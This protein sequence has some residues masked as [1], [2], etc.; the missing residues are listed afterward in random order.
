MPR[1][2]RLGLAVVLITALSVAP[3]VGREIQ[4]VGGGFVAGPIVNPADAG[5][6]SG[7]DVAAGVTELGDTQAP[8]V[9]EAVEAGDWQTVIRLLETLGEGEQAVLIRDSSGMLRPLSTLKAQVLAD[10]PAEGRRTFR[11]MYRPVA[12]KLL[13]D[14]QIIADPGEQTLALA[15]VVERY[16]LCA[17]AADAAQ[18]LGDLHFEGGRF[19]ESVRYYTFASSHAD[20]DPDDPQLIA[21]RLHALARAG[22]WAGFDTLADYARFRRGGAS[23]RIGGETVTVNALIDALGGDRAAGPAVPQQ[24][25]RP[26]GFPRGDYPSIEIQTLDPSVWQIVQQSMMN[27]RVAL[28]ADDMTRPVALAADGRLY[29]LAL[30]QLTAHAPDTGEPLWSVGNAE[31]SARQVANWA[32]QLAMSGIH[33]SLSVE[34]DTLLAIAHDPQQMDM[35]R[36]SAYD[37]ASGA[38]RWST[39]QIAELM[40]VGF[41]GQTATRSRTTYA[42]GKDR[43]GNR[44]T[45]Y[46][47]GLDDGAVE[48]SVPLGEAKPD[49][50]WRQVIGLNPSIAVGE[51]YVFV[52]TNNGALIAVDPVRREVAWAMCYGILPASNPNTGQ[53]N[54][55]SPGGVAVQDGVVFSKDGRDDRL[56]AIRAGDA[57]VQW[58][59]QVDP[60]ATLV[61]CDS[62]HAYL[63]GEELVAYDLTTGERVWWTAHHGRA[64]RAPVFTADHALIAGPHRMC[65]IDLTTGKVDGYREDVPTGSRGS[66]VIRLGRGIAVVGGDRLTIYDTPPDE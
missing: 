29:T 11:M 10:L 53:V 61:H 49:P 4:V 18:Q 39:Q 38:V 33:Q 43:N 46:A 32:H 58:T 31:E 41:L 3:V 36:L 25:D 22:D 47:L 6:E 63:L 35:A 16:G 51:R 65:R 45:L 27:Q 48:W 1:R 64:G 60:G 14:A 40:Q 37:K 15:E 9:F 12:A 5:R 66:E 59:V 8:A 44:L 17:A 54:S 7:F 21:K 13:A 26:L 23:V 34:G 42:V 24:A 19:N 56:I 20:G 50:N 2:D 28:S 62:R 57:V 52:L 55:V 30:G